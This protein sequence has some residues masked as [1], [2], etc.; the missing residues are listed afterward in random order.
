ML[1][2]GLK[3]PGPV[4]GRDKQRRRALAG[5]SMPLMVDAVAALLGQSGFDVIGRHADAG[6]AH[7]A[8]LDEPVDIV[9]FDF[10]D[11]VPSG[12]EML[13]EARAAKLT[14]RII[15]FIA[16]DDVTTPLDAVELAVDGLLLRSA[17]AATVAQCVASVAA[18]EQWLD[19]RAMKMAYDRIAQRQAGHTTLLTRRERDVA[20]LVATGQRNRIIAQQLGISEGT[21][22]MHLHNVYAK[23]GL[24]SRTQLAMDVRP[25]E[26]A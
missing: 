6:R 16:D 5:S 18:G 8:L 26:M 24:E 22:K 9:V 14:S 13:R 21:V 19:P 2:D 4:N 7:R 12:L 3:G 15:L 10:S 17:A 11:T 25:R 1:K 23:L 20:R